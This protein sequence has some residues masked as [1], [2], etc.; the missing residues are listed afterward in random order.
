MASR[1]QTADLIN[2]LWSYFRTTDPPEK[3]VEVW[4]NDL[5]NIDLNN[6]G[7]YI[8]NKIKALDK[9]PSNFP[10][11]VKG[12]YFQWR[13]DQPRETMERGCD[14]CMDGII[15]AKDQHGF[16]YAFGCG[17][18]NTGFSSLPVNTRYNIEDQGYKLDWQHDYDGP[19][20]YGFLN[21]IKKLIKIIE[22]RV[23]MQPEKLPF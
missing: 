12:L 1:S 19:I 11:T 2:E 20:N 4:I 8:K 16:S 13:R 6:A 17:H 21:K 3:S 22:P 10:N 5:T 7:E 23:E 14:R 15:Y 18:C 9:W